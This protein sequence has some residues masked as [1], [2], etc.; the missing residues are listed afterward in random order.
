MLYRQLMRRYLGPLVLMF[1]G[2]A[3][4][5][6]TDSGDQQNGGGSS[7][8]G[9]SS[10]GAHTGGSAGA[11]SG[12]SAGQASGGSNSAGSGG[13]III[14]SG[15]I[16]TGGGITVGGSG[17]S[18]GGVVDARCPAQRP[19]GTCNADDAGLRCEYESFSVCLCYM[20]TPGSYLPCQKVDPQCPNSSVG[21]A[22]GAAAA[23]AGGAGGAAAAGA[24][25]AAAAGAGGISAKIAVAP[26]EVCSCTTA[27]WVCGYAI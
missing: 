27:G 4:G 10:A 5:G 3:C 16:S 13:S 19:M 8:G 23:G 11:A 18:G 22:G 12:G 1:L 21:G 24:G 25:G 26:R 17:G 2:I 9:S 6:T 20:S 15:G 7:S 14:G